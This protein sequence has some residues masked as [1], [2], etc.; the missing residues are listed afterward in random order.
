MY[1]FQA[2]SGLYL[3]CTQL[4]LTIQANKLQSH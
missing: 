2:K 1:K 3:F 4:S